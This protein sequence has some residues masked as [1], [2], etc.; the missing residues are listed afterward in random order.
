MSLSFS[1]ISRPTRPSAAS[2]PPVIPSVAQRRS[3]KALF[4]RE[5]LYAQAQ[6]SY[7]PMAKPDSLKTISLSASPFYY[8][9]P[10]SGVNFFTDF[11][12]GTSDKEAL[13]RFKDTLHFV[14]EAPTAIA[15]HLDDFRKTGRTAP[16]DYFDQAQALR[17]IRAD[18]ERHQAQI[19][20]SLFLK[21]RSGHLEL[22]NFQDIPYGDV[23]YA[24]L[25]LQRL[26]GRKNN[27]IHVHVIDPGVGNDFD[28]S[29]KP[30]HD[31]SILITKNHGILVGPN[32]GSLGLLAKTLEGEG[33]RPE[34]LRINLRQVQE[35]ERLR[36][37]DPAYIIPDTFHARDGFAPVAA[38]I[39]GGLDPHLLGDA[40]PNF[41]V[42]MTPFAEHLTDMP[43]R[44][45]EGRAFEA[46]RDRTFGNVKTNLFLSEKEA[47]HLVAENA[48]F[49]IRTSDNRKEVILPFKAFFSQV[50]QGAPLNY[51]GS[52]YA[53]KPG[54]RLVE[55][56][57]NLG[58]I[59]DRLGI[60]AGKSKT[61]RIERIDNAPTPKK[62][63]GGFS[64]V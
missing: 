25:A 57:V 49:R 37:R 4:G 59:S 14:Q 45:G 48:Q 29:G 31:R 22:Q 26:A 34:L 12:D 19:L 60:Q 15:R 44:H 21:R 39:A 36:R 11:N 13:A 35:L 5:P 30:M 51:L 8:T 3:Q 6:D 56:A 54:S 63:G 62:K 1:A 42:K 18:E 52:T 38:A 17:E 43:L 20:L 47:A 61:L 58:S 46:I 7:T 9:G 16:A 32:N 64:A 53:P 28:A 23:H 33:E 27:E 50:D 2:Q 24:N 41:T 40:D 55:L 10:F